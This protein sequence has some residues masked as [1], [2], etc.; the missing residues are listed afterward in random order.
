MVIIYR[1]CSVINCMQ[2]HSNYGKILSQ[3]GNMSASKVPLYV[4]IYRQCVARS[5]E[6]VQGCPLLLGRLVESTPQ[7]RNPAINDTRATNGPRE[8]ASIRDKLATKSQDSV[9]GIFFHEPR[10]QVFL[11]GISSWLP[12]PPPPTS[13]SK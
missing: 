5:F 13:T 9:L 12:R 1:L 11:A 3:S 7:R 10:L 2:T 6:R 4:A 8:V